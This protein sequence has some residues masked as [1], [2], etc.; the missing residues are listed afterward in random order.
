MN[1]IITY[2]IHAYR[3][4]NVNS[5]RAGYR[6]YFYEHCPCNV[7]TY[8]LY[9]QS[10]LRILITW[11]EIRCDVIHFCKVVKWCGVS[12]PWVRVSLSVY[13]RLWWYLC[14]RTLDIRS[15]RNKQ[16]RTDHRSEKDAEENKCDPTLTALTALVWLSAK[17][18]GV[19]CETGDSALWTVGEITTGE[20][21]LS[22]S[23]S[24][25]YKSGAENLPSREKRGP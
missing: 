25:D 19:D 20:K 22:W 8:W 6:Y 5:G 3:T 2:K 11:Y 16:T 15:R 13:S 9:G 1:I 24:A 7:D 18:L 14:V 4:W 10:Y 23:R 12:P 21:P 17:K